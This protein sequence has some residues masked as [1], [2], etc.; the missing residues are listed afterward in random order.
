MVIKKQNSQYEIQNIIVPAMT[1]SAQDN[2]KQ[3]LK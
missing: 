3:V 2:E 1:L